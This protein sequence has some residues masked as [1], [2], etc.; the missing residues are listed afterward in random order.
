M[1]DAGSFLAIATIPIGK[2]VTAKAGPLTLDLDTIWT[3]AAAGAVVLG[4]GLWMRHKATSGVPSKAQLVWELVVGYVDSLIAQ[5]L[6]PRYRRIAPL[7]VTMFTLILVA[8]WME[9]LPGLYHNTDF[10]PSPSADVNFTYAL[11]VLVM[12][13]TNWASFRKRGF[14]GYVQHFF[15]PPR[16]MVPMHFLEE[17]TK[18]LTLALRL[19]GNLFS[20]GIMI[21]L[22]L[23]FPLLF[24]PASVAF[25]LVWKLFDMFIGV[26]Q[27]FIFGL[28]TVLYYQFAVTDEEEAGAH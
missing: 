28:L 23:S 19:F 6:G 4:L 8:N 18:P 26:I 5:G 9:I 22:L 11:A 21:A 7:V 27:A 15:R 16:I 2:H 1:A 13:L 10:S 25:T 12:V 14:K 3:T 20:G 17:L 24:A